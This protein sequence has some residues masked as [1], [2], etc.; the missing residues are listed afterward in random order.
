MKVL[1][2]GASGTI[3]KAIVEALAQHEVLRAGR[4]GDVKVDLGDAGSIR[5]MYEQAG[6]LDAV[7]AAAGRAEFGTVTSLTDE[8]LDFALGTMLRGAI[9]L[10][11]YG[12]DAMNDGGSFTLTSGDLTDAPI[13]ESAIVT[14]VGAAIEAF[15]RTAALS[16][17]RGNRINVVSPALVAESAAKKG[18]DAPGVPAS[19]TASWYVESVTGSRTGSVRTP[20]GWRD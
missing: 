12:V 4:K 6:K 2:V 13:P 7:V 20:D 16:M 9:D 3:G 15:A 5:A 17:P 1:V 14:P 8:A 11:R 10:V 18:I 19:T